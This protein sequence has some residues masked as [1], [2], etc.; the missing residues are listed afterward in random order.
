MEFDREPPVVGYPV[1]SGPSLA[2]ATHW[3]RASRSAASPATRRPI[4]L[5]RPGSP[6]RGKQPP[7]PCA[8]SCITGAALN[9]AEGQLTAEL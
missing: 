9:A 5:Q 1:E 6:L 7:I 4:R 3:G 2:G 8:R